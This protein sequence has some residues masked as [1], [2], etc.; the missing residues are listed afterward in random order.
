MYERLWD[1]PMTEKWIVKTHE[2]LK[3]VIAEAERLTNGGTGALELK[4][5]ETS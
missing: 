5:P 1:T 4:F 2:V 3:Q